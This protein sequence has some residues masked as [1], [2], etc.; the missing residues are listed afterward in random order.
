MASKEEIIIMSKLAI[1]DKRHGE[2]DKKINALY[3][4]DYVYRRNLYARSLSLLGCLMIVVL[5]MTNILLDETADLFLIDF[6]EI[7]INAAIFVSV[8]MVFYTMVGSRIAT[9]EYKRI[10][11]RIKLYFILIK[12]LEELREKPDIDDD[13]NY[14][15]EELSKKERTYLHSSE[16]E[17][18]LHY[19]S[20][21][22]DKRS[23]Y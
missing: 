18:K 6:R 13:D 15:F 7:G 16:E 17:L 1:Y 2:N 14:D 5:Y 19:E 11:K 21:T 20:T 23:D 4:R 3:Y 10:K 12:E 22:R 9:K 8:V